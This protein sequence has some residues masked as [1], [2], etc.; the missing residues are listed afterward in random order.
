MLVREVE[1][2]VGVGPD[3]FHARACECCS[4]AL[5]AVGRVDDDPSEVVAG[6]D[7]TVGPLMEVG[8]GSAY[9]FPRHLGDQHQSVGRRREHIGAPT[10]TPGGRSELPYT[11]DVGRGCFADEH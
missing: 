2:G 1:G 10:P 8:L 6:R 3:P 5:A 9:E 4:E 7:V 11:L